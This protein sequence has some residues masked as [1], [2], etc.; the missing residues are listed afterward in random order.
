MAH[1]LKL[2]LWGADHWVDGARTQGRGRLSYHS[3]GHTEL[4]I[5]CGEL[6]PEWIWP[7]HKVEVGCPYTQG[8]TLVD[9]YTMGS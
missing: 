4:Q 2:T 9:T 3:G 1:W 8:G 6:T 5:H 7:E